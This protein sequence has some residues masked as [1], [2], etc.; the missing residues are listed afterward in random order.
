[1]ALI[2][3][4]RGLAA[5]VLVLAAAGCASGP[6]TKS[7]A[8]APKRTAAA[9]RPATAPPRVA[10]ASDW[11]S[12]SR[13]GAALS[14]EIERRVAGLASGPVAKRG[15]QLASRKLAASGRDL[16]D[17]GSLDGAEAALQKAISL[18]G[19]DGYAY[20]FLA[21][22]HHVK[23]REELAAEFASSAGRY[24]PDDKGVRS[25]LAGLEQSI[26]AGSPVAGDPARR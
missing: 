26:R 24:L 6:A 20:L 9:T 23:G 4:R 19:A 8:K 1:M 3:R 22:V 7:A 5:I 14:D 2:S 25:E 15:Q 18:D 16:I 10:A 12:F 13:T 21:Y 11:E 17:A